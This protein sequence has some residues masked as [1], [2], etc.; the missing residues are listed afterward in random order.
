MPTSAAT[1][2]ADGA[3]GAAT[4]TGCAGAKTTAGSASASSASVDASVDGGASKQ[5]SATS[6]RPGSIAAGS[7]ASIVAVAPPA[8]TSAPV[9]HAALVPAGRAAS[10]HSAPGG[11]PRTVN[12]SA[13]VTGQ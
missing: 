8:A 5:R 3:H 7:G 6:T 4:V 12:R 11:S 10:A 9:A 13:E 2:E 1:D